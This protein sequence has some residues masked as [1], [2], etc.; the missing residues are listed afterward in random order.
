ML[1]NEDTE[2][3][4]HL[5]A[6]YIIKRITVFNIF[7]RH[8]RPKLRILNITLV[9]NYLLAQRR[10]AAECSQRNRLRNRDVFDDTPP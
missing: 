4:T 2:S 8:G 1:L 6:L 10:W 3:H 7:R 5:N 9:S